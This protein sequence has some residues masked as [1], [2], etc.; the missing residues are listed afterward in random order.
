[1]RLRRRGLEDLIT[2]AVSFGATCFLGV[3]Q[4]MVVAIS[5]SIVVFVFNSTYPQF[6]EIRRTPG[7]MEYCRLPQSTSL[8]RDHFTTSSHARHKVAVKLIRFEAPLWF[9]NS[10]V[11]YDHML[12]E[13]KMAGKGV[14]LD[15]S[16]V[17]W[18]DITGGSVLK[19]VLDRAEA[20]EVFL[21]FAN[22]SAEVQDMIQSVCRVNTGHFFDSTYEAEAAVERSEPSQPRVYLDMPSDSESEDAVAEPASVLANI[23]TPTR[24]GNETKLRERT[25]SAAGSEEGDLPPAR[26][27]DF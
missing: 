13:V 27:V 20:C 2:L 15:M 8:C 24:L 11:F 16:S 19:K 18:V 12:Q 25:P 5:F 4:G 21:A 22:T 3:I 7:T 9:G 14:V 6:V 26:T 1:L 10:T 23:P 17:P